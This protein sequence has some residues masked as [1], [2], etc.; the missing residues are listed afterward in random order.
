VSL[1]GISS[2][3]FLANNSS[4]LQ[5]KRHE[6][7]HEFQQLGQ[8]LQSGNTTAAQSDF[9]TLQQLVP[10]L[11]TG[12]PQ[13]YDPRVRAFDQLGQHLQS[14]N[15]SAAQQDYAKLQDVLQSQAHFHHQ[16][17]WSDP[18]STSEQTQP[19]SASV[20]VSA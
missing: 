9:T 3:S 19:A 12:A 8:D 11:S 2:T 5:S 18:E 14:G 20:S 17:R 13:S 1:S 6:V 7:Q 16:Q 15:I 4:S 10:K